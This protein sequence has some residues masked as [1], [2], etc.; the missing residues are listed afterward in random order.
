[1]LTVGTAHKSHAIVAMQCPRLCPPYG[2]GRSHLRN[3]FNLSISAMAAAGARTLAPEIMYMN[4]SRFTL[5]R[6]VAASNARSAGV[7]PLAKA[8]AH[9][10]QASSAAGA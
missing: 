7:A 6:G 10:A 5:P 1:M 9:L 2:A 4:T 8:S 3:Y